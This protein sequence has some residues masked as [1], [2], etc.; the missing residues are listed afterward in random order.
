MTYVSFP[1]FFERIFEI[2]PV[3]FS[4]FGISVHWYGLIICTGIILAVLTAIKCAK[5]EGISTDDVLDFALYAVP[6]AI[7]GARLYYV[8]TSDSS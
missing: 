5:R 3:A 8:I 1:A 6:I 7:I 2:N 4:V